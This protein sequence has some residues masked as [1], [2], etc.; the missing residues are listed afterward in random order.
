MYLL[1]WI[2][3]DAL[4]AGIDTRGFTWDK[5]LPGVILNEVYSKRYTGQGGTS[6]FTDPIPGNI[7]TL[8]DK[9]ECIN[10]NGI[11]EYILTLW[12]SLCTW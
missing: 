9:W 7:Q 2:L 5:W 11:F 3:G 8:M 6:G 1:R 10:P 12:P 4:T